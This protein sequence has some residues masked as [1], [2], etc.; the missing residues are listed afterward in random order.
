MATK[1]LAC[2][3]ESVVS[4]FVV[5]DPVPDGGGLWCGFWR[6]DQSNAS[7]R[8]GCGLSGHGNSE[9]ALGGQ[10]LEGVTSIRTRIS[11]GMGGVVDVDLAGW[12]L[13]IQRPKLK[14]GFFVRIQAS[15]QG[16][17]RESGR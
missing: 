14:W 13:L 3:V 2:P 15:S 4:C 5:K 16:G 10:T 8:H 17:K 1:D 9:I 6:R 11:L 7:R 12:L